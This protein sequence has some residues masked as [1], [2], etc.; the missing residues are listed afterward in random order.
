MAAFESGPPTI[1]IPAV[2]AEPAPQPSTRRRQLSPVQARVYRALMDGIDAVSVVDAGE[3]R[4]LRRCLSDAAGRLSGRVASG[5]LV[6]SRSTLPGA[7]ACPGSVGEDPF[8]WTARS[9]A[10]SL[11]L[12]ALWQMVRDHRMD[13]LAAVE[14]TLIEVESEVPGRPLG[15]WLVSLSPAQ[16]AAVSAQACSWATRA[17]TAVPWTSLGRIRPLFASLY[18][19]PGRDGPLTMVARPDVQVL[20]RRGSNTDVV[21]LSIGA[22]SAPAQRLDTLVTAFRLGRAPLRSVRVD[23][24]SGSVEV[25]DVTAQSLEQAVNEVLRAAEGLLAVAA[26]GPKPALLNP[27]PHCWSCQRLASCPTG[28]TWTAARARRFAGLPVPDPAE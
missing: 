12:P 26:Q 18:W 13:P 25:A 5:Q 4:T 17:W 22:P 28:Q 20:L 23:P 16:R 3:V 6:L 14:R 21:L 27:G 8:A 11:G 24:A 7:L 10:R 19:N 2:I 15:Q 1:G 9:A